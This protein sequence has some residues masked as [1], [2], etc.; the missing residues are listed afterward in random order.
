MGT[1]YKGQ[2]GSSASAAGNATAS[3]CPRSTH[4]RDISLKSKAQL[5]LM[6][7]WSLW[8]SVSLNHDAAPWWW[9]RRPQNPGRWFKRTRNQNNSL[10]CTR[11]RGNISLWRIQLLGH[12]EANADFTDRRAFQRLR[13]DEDKVLS[14]SW[15]RDRSANV[16][17]LNINLSQ[18]KHVI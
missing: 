16:A 9:K 13:I 17:R 3:S 12:R 10:R 11:C 6:C 4:T 8:L 15:S 18:Q 5:I 1:L 14:A 2:T 7:S